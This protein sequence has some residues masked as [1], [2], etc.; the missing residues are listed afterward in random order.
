MH[1]YGNVIWVQS[2]TAER[3]HQAYRDIARKFALPGWDDPKSNTFRMVSEWLSDKD[4]GTWLM[5][6]DDVD[7]DETFMSISHSILGR[8][9]PTMLGSYLPQSSNGSIIV[10]TRDTRLGGRLMNKEGSVIILPF[11]VHE[12]QLLL[13]FKVTD[14]NWVEG[15]AL[16]LLKMLG[17]LPLAVTQ[18]AAFISKNKV[19]VAE[20]VNMLRAYDSQLI[21]QLYSYPSQ[22]IDASISVIKT[23]T[24]SFGHITKEQPRAAQTLSRMAVLDRQRIP[25]TLLQSDHESAR[26]LISTLSTL[27]S[28][29]L[30]DA[31]S[32]GEFFTLS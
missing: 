25:K 32:K 27:Q 11:D 15:D 9:R 8:H 23:W 24:L 13:R 4:H 26:E 17:Y 19:S 30:I 5:I 18:A 1:P 7:D 22:D 12:A 28:F 21:R 10:T 14:E 31:E 29:S 3:F 20:Y 2:S 16:E 6:L